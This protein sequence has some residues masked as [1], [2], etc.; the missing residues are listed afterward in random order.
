[1]TVSKCHIFVRVSSSRMVTFERKIKVLRKEHPW[2]PSPVGEVKS[3]SSSPRAFPERAHST[4]W[5]EQVSVS[6]WRLFHF[7]AGSNARVKGL[8]FVFST[9]HSLFAPA[10]RY[11][12]DVWRLP[13]G[14]GAS[15]F[16]FWHISSGFRYQITFHWRGGGRKDGNRTY[17]NGD[18]LEKGGHPVSE[19]QTSEGSAQPGNSPIQ[20]GFN[21]LRDHKNRPPGSVE[22]APW[23][24]EASDRDSRSQARN[25]GRR[26][27]FCRGRN[28][29]WRVEDR[30]FQSRRASHVLEETLQS[31]DGPAG[32][33]RLQVGSCLLELCQGLGPLSPWCQRATVRFRTVARTPEASRRSVRQW[34][35]F[36]LYFS[37]MAHVPESVYFSDGVRIRVAANDRDLPRRAFRS[38]HKCVGY[39]QLSAVR[40]QIQW[41]CARLSVGLCD[42]P[43]LDRKHNNV[44][45]QLS[46]W[47]HHIPG[48]YCVPASSGLPPNRRSLF[49]FLFPLY[50]S[51]PR[52]WVQGKL[53][54]ERGSL[55]FVYQ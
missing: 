44:L 36:L 45:R 20:R 5:Q 24:Q 2:W 7:P 47:R 51:K 9:S 32:R 49:S 42:R 10:A 18:A 8:F 50:H 48:G 37:P 29:G 27:E 21:A 33:H 30:W 16:R 46:L 12:Y 40:G 6:Q 19:Q 4:W 54:R 53:Y 34:R 41:Q 43:G 14:S 17:R 31:S 13:Q 23:H 39:L 15:K 35:P 25:I 22:E 28:D 55:Q 26:C 38:E 3:P 1:M 52:G 11:G